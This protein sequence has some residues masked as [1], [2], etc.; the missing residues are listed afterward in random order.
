M[1]PVTIHPHALTFFIKRY[2]WPSVIALLLLPAGYLVLAQTQV[3]AFALAVWAVAAII[4]SVALIHTHLH[5]RVYLSIS[6]EEIIYETSIFSQNKVVVPLNKITDTAVTASW[7][8]RIL[9]SATLHIN[10]AGGKE[11]EIVAEDFSKSGV[12]KVSA[13]LTSLMRQMP[14]SLPDNLAVKKSEE[15]KK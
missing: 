3:M 11:F 9:G 2:A 15:P 14:G 8:D 7:F 5:Q 4:L 6:G 10:T 1:E 12:D 13:M